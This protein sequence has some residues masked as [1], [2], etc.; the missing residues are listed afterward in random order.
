ME[1]ALSWEE[2]G[3]EELRQT[4]EDYADRAEQTFEQPT[5]VEVSLFRLGGRGHPLVERELP[6][7]S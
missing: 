1:A 4:A 5:S 3:L 6:S 7:E 2:P